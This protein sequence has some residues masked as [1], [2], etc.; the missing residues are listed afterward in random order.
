M[1]INLCRSIAPRRQHSFSLFLSLLSFIPAYLDK[2]STMF[3]TLRLICFF[4][5]LFPVAC[6]SY[7]QSELTRSLNVAV[8]EKKI[9]PEKMEKILE[10]YEQLK[11]KDEEIARE[12]VTKIVSAIEMGADSSH[13]D[14]VRRRVVHAGPKVEV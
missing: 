6:T 7:K 12:Y 14:V 10:E 2:L 9:S 11:E 4:A 8:K 13:I 5:L 3:R 1:L